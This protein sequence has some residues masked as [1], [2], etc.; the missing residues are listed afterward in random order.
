M[1]LTKRGFGVTWRT[2]PAEALAVLESDDRIEA[3]VTDLRMGQASGLDLCARVVT[4]WPDRPVIVMTAFGSLDDHERAIPRLQWMRASVRGDSLVLRAQLLQAGRDAPYAPGAPGGWMLQVFL[5]TDE[6][7]TGYWRGY[8][9]IVRG[10]EWSDGRFVVRLI[11]PGDEWPGGWGPPSGSALFD[12]RTRSFTVTIPR[13]ALGGDD[14]RVAYG[15]E[16]YETVA[17]PECPGGYSHAYFDH[18]F[19]ATDDAPGRGTVRP[20][21]EL[22]RGVPRYGI[23][24]PPSATDAYHQR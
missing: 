8:D 3:V 19:G 14:G 15:L 22:E 12:P 11:Q 20:A 13:S 23:A 10:G 6:R 7:D 5:N 21:G 4:V 2:S 18:W 24:A 16:F 17:C 1:A 9:Y